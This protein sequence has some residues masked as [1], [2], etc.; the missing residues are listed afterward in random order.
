[1]GQVGENEGG[2]TIEEIDEGYG[3]TGWGGV[4]DEIIRNFPQGFVL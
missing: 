1:M 3:G 4:R 2:L